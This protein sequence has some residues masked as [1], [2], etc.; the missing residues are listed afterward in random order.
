MTP[1]SRRPLKSGVSAPGG[2]LGVVPRQ[3]PTSGPGSRRYSC[4]FPPA[5]YAPGKFAD[6]FPLRRKALCNSADPL[7]PARQAP[8]NP[9]DPFQLQPGPVCN[10]KD[11]HLL[12]PERLF[13]LADPFPVAGKRVF[14]TVRVQ[15]M[16][17][18]PSEMSQNPQNSQK[19]PNSQTDP[20]NPPKYPS[21]CN[22][23]S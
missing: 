2:T 3:R 21:I 1:V 13:H 6:R 10:L 12:Q 14:N 17:I 20:I 8:G 19:A 9:A 7:P 23:K 11:P 22:L 5:N 16:P 18:Y 15:F 4:P